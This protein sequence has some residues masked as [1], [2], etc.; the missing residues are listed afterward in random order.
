MYQS[1]ESLILK[2]KQQF[3]FQSDIL[4]K[5]IEEISHG[6]GSENP[7]VECDQCNAIAPNA[8]HL[9]EQD[10]LAQKQASQLFGCFDPGKNTDHSHYD[11]VN[12]IGIYPSSNN[13]ELTTNRM[14][15]TD[16]R[17][18]VRSLNKEQKQFFNHVLHS[19]KVSDDQ[20]SLFLSGGA[21][22][23]KSWLTNALYEAVTKYLNHVVGE[24]P[25]EAKV[26]KLAPTGKAAYNIRGNTVHSA[27][28]LPANRGFLYTAL[29]NDRLNTI[30]S[31]LR[32][33]KVVLTDEISMVGS[34]MFN[35]VNAI[36][37]CKYYCCRR[38]VSASTSV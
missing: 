28:Q 12:D 8:Q 19:V 37:R 25:D 22:V 38:F 16:F 35:F 30:R 17:S 18:L 27:L 1:L 3:E 24:N 32:K 7:V 10:R 26:I 21:G 9:D 33:L 4:D 14:N 31:K 34:G 36:W 6:E 13:V 11:L 23:G 20:L 5:A 2:N 15:D 29:D